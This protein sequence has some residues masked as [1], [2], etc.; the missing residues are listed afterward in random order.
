MVYQGL[1]GATALAICLASA[2]AFA[3]GKAFVKS[4]LSPISYGI[5]KAVNVNGAVAAGN[6]LSKVCF[7]AE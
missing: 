7:L 1:I 6:Q 5:E 4:P 2:G 3:P